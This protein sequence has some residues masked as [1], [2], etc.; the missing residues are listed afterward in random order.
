MNNRCNMQSMSP[1]F[2]SCQGPMPSTQWF[3]L[4]TVKISVCG[5]GVIPKKCCDRWFNVCIFAIYLMII[6][7]LED[8]GESRHSISSVYILQICLSVCLMA[9]FYAD[10]RR[11]EE[12]AHASYV[13]APNSITFIQTWI[14][15]GTLYVLHPVFFIGH[16]EPHCH[17]TW[18]KPEKEVERQAG[19]MS[20]EIRVK[21]VDAFNFFKLKHT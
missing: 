13:C 5:I 7:G 9:H 15:H 11:Y 2:R 18:Q 6:K 12:L 3:G 20:Q 21:Q 16:S 4:Q 1:R 14:P 17:V 8:S 10:L 19:V